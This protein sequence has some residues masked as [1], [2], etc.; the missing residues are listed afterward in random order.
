MIVDVRVDF[1]DVYMYTQPLVVTDTIC[2]EFP[3]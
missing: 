3:C 1:G 2:H